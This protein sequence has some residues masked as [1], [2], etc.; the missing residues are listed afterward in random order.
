MGH[1]PL[2]IEILPD[3]KGVD[4]TAPGKSA[5]KPRSTRMPG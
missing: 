4:L 5:L 3:I 2:M 1:A